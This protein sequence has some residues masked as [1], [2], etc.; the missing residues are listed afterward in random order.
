MDFVEGLPVSKGK[1]VVLVVVDRLLGYAHFIP[2]SHLYTTIVTQIFFD[3]VFKLHGMPRT[4]VSDYCYNTSWHSAVKTTLF[5]VVY[6]RPPPSLLTYVSGTTKAESVERQLLDRDQKIKELR[7]TLK[8]A[9]SRMKK[10]YDYFKLSPRYY[11]S[12]QIVKRIGVV[13]YKLDL[14]EES[15]IHLVFHVSL[16]KKKV[17]DD[18]LVQTELL[19]VREDN[20]TLHSKPQA[21]LDQIIHKR[22][23]QIIIHCQGMSL[24]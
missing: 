6:G 23:K 2:L 7:V 20:K 13:A 17:G 16:L 1:S 15:R 5:E 4:I 9:Q 18:T 22:K 11:G 24:A 8:E 10:V 14:P 12:Y 19:S 3:Q 21:V